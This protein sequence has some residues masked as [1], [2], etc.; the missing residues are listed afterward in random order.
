VDKIKNKMNFTKHLSYK[1]K[2]YNGTMIET[3]LT[4]YNNI[5]EKIKKHD[6]SGHSDSQLKIISGR[7]KSL[8]GIK[9]PDEIII[10]AYAL[11][12]EA[13][14]RVLDIIPHDEQLLAAIVLHRGKLVQMQTGEGKTL[15]AVFPAYLNALKGKSVY[16][17]TA[18]SYLAKR[19]AL[20]MGPLYGFLGLESAY[21]NETLSCEER[22][23]VY[24]KDVVYLTVKEAGFDYLRDG[25]C[26]DKKNIMQRSYNY[27][28]V[29]EADFTL[30]DEARL[31]L[32]IADRNI[33]LEA[34]FNKMTEITDNLAAGVDYNFDGR[35]R[36]AYLLDP[37]IGKIE[38]NLGCGNLYDEKNMDIL[39]TINVILQA[40]CFYRMDFD[41]IIR[42]GK[43]ELI[44]E[45]TGRIAIGRRLP[46]GIQNALEARHGLEILPEGKMMNSITIQH[47]MK[48]FP[49]IAAM[50]ATAVEAAD[51]FAEIYDLDIVII[52]PHKPCIRKDLPDLFF[53][54][55]YEKYKAILED[56]TCQYD[57]GRPVLIG[58]ACINEL[59]IISDMLA[60]K[61]I[62]HK[63]LNAKNDEKE[64]LIIAGA[65]DLFS[66]TI[67]TNMAGRGTDIRLGGANEVN[68]KKVKLLGGLHVIGTTRF[69]LRR[70][71]RH[72]AGRSGR[73]G[74]PGSSQFYF[75]L[76][77][78]IVNRYKLEGIIRDDPEG[79][80]NDRI[81]EKNIRRIQSVI[82]NF[83]FLIRNTLIKYSDIVE[84]QRLGILK[85]RLDILNGNIDDKTDMFILLKDNCHALYE[86]ANLIHGKDKS[87]LIG[88]KILL[89]N[90]DRFWSNHLE[91]IAMLMENLHLHI[92][93]NQNPLYEFINETDRLFQ[94]GFEKMK[95]DIINEFS[96]LDVF[97]INDLIISE[98][99][100]FDTLTYIMED[101]SF[102]KLQSKIF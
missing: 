72:L 38:K 88:K 60:G 6:Y 30:I 51:D 94:D 44:D 61:N 93:S 81:Q 79:G 96:E 100:S 39:S 82:A 33:F 92:Y 55:K 2:S 68:S 36:N 64:A 20:W 23:K 35:T 42:N 67:S 1:M 9:P 84:R 21:V 29:D 66:V 43:I 37:G 45:F 69:D 78:D 49:K 102:I 13:C 15:A 10:D 57:K 17:M 22:K 46:H 83:H 28:I 24:Q 62:N 32:V 8:A 65:G 99:Q 54:T 26:Y 52:P 47:Y 58:T 95:F 97:N 25:I 87:Q 41:Y 70:I 73:Q 4:P 31:P 19:D 56:I 85:I 40:R 59:K 80:I 89:S 11:A 74:D 12:V 101:Y 98:N 75:S 18:N 3:D 63:V 71:D 48:L 76:E 90:I 34:D 5:L 14:K 53:K 50:T 7:I 27:I 77:D 86:Y 16:I 91:C